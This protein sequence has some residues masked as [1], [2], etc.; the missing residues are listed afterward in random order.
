MLAV[1]RQREDCL[2]LCA[3]RGWTDVAE[4]QD[5]DRSASRY[6][7]ET[8]HGKYNFAARKF[9]L[10]TRAVNATLV[11][12]LFVGASVLSAVVAAVAN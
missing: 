6:A 7:L 8:S 5:N 4:Y 3:D 10:L 12:L 11:S 1:D 9:R 2:K